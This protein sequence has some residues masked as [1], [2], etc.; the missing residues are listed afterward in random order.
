MYRID[1]L[2]A[3]IDIVPSPYSTGG[4][5][6]VVKEDDGSKATYT[7]ASRVAA[8]AEEWALACRKARRD[9]AIPTAELLSYVFIDAIVL[10]H[11]HNN[12][13]NAHLFDH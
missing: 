3:K 2:C 12:K 7:F 9:D 6:F 1:L 5:A 10:F 8:T 13:L 4:L 11:H